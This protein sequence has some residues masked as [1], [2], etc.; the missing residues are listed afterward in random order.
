MSGERDE[1]EALRDA[2]SDEARGGDELSNAAPPMASVRRGRGWWLAA[3][4]AEREGDVTPGIEEGRRGRQMEDD[5]AHRRD[6]MDAELEQPLTQRGH[7]R[8]GAGRA[9]GPQ[10]EFLHEHVRGGGE[11]HAQLIGPEAT[12]AG[13][14]DLEAVVEFLDP[15]FNVAACTIDTLVDEARRLPQIRDHKARVVTGL[16]AGKANDFGFDDNAALVGPRPGGIARLG[17][18]VFGLPA[19]LAL[20]PGLAHGGLRAPPVRCPAGGSPHTGTARLRR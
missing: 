10:P 2:E 18:D 11:E 20:G 6:D 12:A 15:I 3:A 17:V 13:A 14:S 9:R 19:R 5:A 7:L 4:G 16:T 8:V 1:A